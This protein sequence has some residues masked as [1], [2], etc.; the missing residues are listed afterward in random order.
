MR[1]IGFALILNALLGVGAVIASWRIGQS[2]LDNLRSATTF[3]A[4]E[5]SGFVQSL[6]GV[7]ALVGDAADATTGFG[8]SADRA[9]EAVASGAPLTSSSAP[10]N[11]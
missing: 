5:Q 11:R 3:L 4:P 2:M 9:R 1:V 7:A 10:F 8:Q 6:R